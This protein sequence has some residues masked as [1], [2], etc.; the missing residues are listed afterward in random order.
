MYTPA[1]FAEERPEVIARLIAEHPFGVLFTCGAD[2]PQASHLPFLLD[3]TRGPQG[4][5][6]GHLAR[7]NAHWQALDGRAEALVVF[8]G[9]HG[10]VSPRWYRRKPAVPTWNYAAVHVHGR[11]RL[12]YDAPSLRAILTA[13]VDRFEDGAERWGM[14]SVPETFLSGLQRAIIGVEIEVTRIEAKLKLS[15]NRGEDD[16][17]GV[18]AALLDSPIDGDRALG[19]MMRD[20]A[21]AEA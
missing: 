8:N 11:P 5:L 17:A 19:R 14:D 4:T 18:V 12:I 6:I 2:G 9:P 15:Q 16:R 3:E 20:M 21:P 13:L 7:A 10:Y 1:P